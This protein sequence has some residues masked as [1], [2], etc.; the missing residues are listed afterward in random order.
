VQRLAPQL[1]GDGFDDLR[2][3]VA[4]VEDAESAQ[5]V[6]VFAAVDVAIGVRPG[7]G[8]FDDGA[9]ALEVAGL[10]V[11]EEARID[12]IAET[13]DGFAGD[14]ARVLGRDVRFGNQVENGLRVLDNVAFA[15]G[16]NFLS[17]F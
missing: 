11:F 15:I 2:M 9:G 3:A 5:A 12:V 17:S 6:D 7:V 4:D 16:R 1:I 8:P 13:L 10:A 14:P